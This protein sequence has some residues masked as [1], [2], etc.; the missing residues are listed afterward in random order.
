MKFT[1]DI[2]LEKLKKYKEKKKSSN[3]DKNYI[4]IEKL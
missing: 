1:T 2:S 4:D 3:E